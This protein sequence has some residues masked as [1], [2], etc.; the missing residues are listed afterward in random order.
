MIPNSVPNR[1]ALTLIIAGLGIVLSIFFGQFKT[2]RHRICFEYDGKQA[3]AVTTLRDKF[4]EE[5][6]QHYK[7]IQDHINR[8]GETV[9]QFYAESKQRTLIKALALKLERSNQII[10]LHSYLNAISQVIEV[11]LWVEASI[12][13]VGIGLV[14]FTVPHHWVV[15][16]VGIVTF[17]SLCII[18][19]VFVLLYFEGKF[20]TA[21]NRI[22]KPEFD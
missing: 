11:V 20:L 19:L 16:L 4:E 9:Q 21:A 3:A 13:M 15:A 6:E 22:L 10:R 5:A 1:D 18:V 7:T 17:L 8:T 14:W 12:L 2:W